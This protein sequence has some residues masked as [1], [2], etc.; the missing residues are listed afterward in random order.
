M[1]Q[2]IG[3]TGGIASGKSNVC[4][5]IRS[6]GYKVIDL[7][8]ITHNLYKKGNSIYNA[9]LDTFGLDYLDSN[10]EID[11]LK[12]GKYIFQ[13]EKAKEKLNSITHPL[14]LAKMKEEID[15]LNER[16]IFLDIPLLFE[17]KLEYLC[18]KII[19][20]YLEESLQVKRLM[21][22]DHID[23]DYAMLKIHSQMDLNIKKDKADYVIHSKG[24]LDETEALVKTIINEI[25][26]E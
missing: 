4:N 17:A 12:L 7:D 2:L 5:V 10:L 26:G 8:E 22:R 9:I 24:S 18:D 15:N 21:E 3:V 16:I 19:C 20:V 14:I 11:R 13:N 25:E 23:Y 1:K 6:L